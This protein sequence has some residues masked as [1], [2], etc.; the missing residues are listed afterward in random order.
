LEGVGRVMRFSRTKVLLGGV[1]LA[2]ASVGAAGASLNQSKSSLP[3]KTNEDVAKLASSE[4]AVVADLNAYKKLGKSASVAAISSKLRADENTQNL[5]AAAVNADLSGATSVSRGHTSAGGN[6]SSPSS[7]IPFGQTGSIDG[8]TVKVVAV[9]SAITDPIDEIQPPAGYLCE[10]I[11]LQTTRTASQ[12]ETPVMLDDV[13]LGSN[14]AQ[15][16][17]GDQ[18][19]C[20]TA[21]NNEPYNNVVEDGGTVNTGDAISVPVSDTNLVLGVGTPGIKQLWFKTTP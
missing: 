1:L 13:L 19:D 20:V 14:L 16:G 15:R 17:A 3:S 8:W 7:A 4:N 12:G 10:S 6:G 2:A 9:T 21:A 18:P 11:T 5:L